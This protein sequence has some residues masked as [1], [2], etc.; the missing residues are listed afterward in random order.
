MRDRRIHS[1]LGSDWNVHICHLG[2]AFQ[3]H[4]C[5][6]SQG[7]VELR[8]PEDW[9]PVINQSCDL[10]M[11]VND[12]H[13]LEVCMSVCWISNNSVGMKFSTLTR[14]QQRLLNRLLSELSQKVML[15]ESQLIM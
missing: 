15:Q 3:T 6:I 1:R 10:S 8:R 14:A 5:N 13:D 9:L 12:K 11:P 7:G 4:L 2:N